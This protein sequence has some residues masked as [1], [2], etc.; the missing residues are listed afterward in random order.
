MADPKASGSGKVRTRPPGDRQ[1]NLVDRHVGERVRARRKQLGLSQDRLAESLGLTFQ[2][3]QKYERGAN[4]ISA[5][6]LFDAAAALQVEIAYFFDGLTPGAGL[7]GVSEP[8][9]PA[10]QHLTL[11]TEDTDLITAFHAIGR[12]RMRRRIFELVREIA[13]EEPGADAAE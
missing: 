3:V 13:A 5:S 4:R 2:Q 6:K 7:E 1:P 9:A 10:F 12:K 11:S 8:E